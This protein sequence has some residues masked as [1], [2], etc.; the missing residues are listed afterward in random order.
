MKVLIDVNPNTILAI[1][2][3]AGPRSTTKTLSEAANK[4]GKLFER[5][6][7]YTG[8]DPDSVATI[9]D[10]IDTLDY[11]LRNYADRIVDD[12]RHNYD[13]QRGTGKLHRTPRRAAAANNT[14]QRTKGKQPRKQRLAAEKDTG[15]APINNQNH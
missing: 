15:A 12:N 6:G 2:F 11:Q 1:E 4:I 9:L 13:D 3:V 7:V 5:Y 14:N 10:R 8:Y